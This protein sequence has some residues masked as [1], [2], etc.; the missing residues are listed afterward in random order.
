MMILTD[1]QGMG[2]KEATI[3]VPPTTYGF[4]V[5]FEAVVGN[6]VYSEIAIDDVT[7]SN[8]NC[9][10]PGMVIVNCTHLGSVCK[11]CCVGSACKLC[12]S[13]YSVCKLY[14]SR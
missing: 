2:W 13:G 14:S 4:S 10:H 1:N 8:T 11:L 3:S 6:N 12:S 7:I 5:V 9:T